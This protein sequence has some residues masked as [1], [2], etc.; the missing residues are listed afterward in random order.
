MTRVQA[1]LHELLVSLPGVIDRAV[2]DDLS[3]FLS[4][5]VIDRSLTGCQPLDDL[6]LGRLVVRNHP[7]RLPGSYRDDHSFFFEPAKLAF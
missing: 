2:R 3:T 6:N 5:K 4:E 1:T 7:Q